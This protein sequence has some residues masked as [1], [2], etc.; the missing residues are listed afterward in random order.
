MIQFKDI[1]KTFESKTGIVHAVKEVNL[2]V[3]AGEIFGVIGYSGAGKSTLV[4]LINLLERPTSGSVYINGEDITLFSP[5]ALRERRKKIGMIFQQFNL[6]SARTVFENIALPLKRQGLSNDEIRTRVIELLELVGILDKS[7]AYPSQL[8]GGQKQRVAIA[9]ALAN[10]P[11]ILLCD[12]AT[13]ALDPQTTKTILKLL[14]DLN[15]KLN[16][17]IVVIT[18]EMEVVKEICDRVAVMQD[19]F[20]VEL[21]TVQQIFSNPQENITKEF[22]STTSNLSKLDDLLE[23]NSDI[24]HLEPHQKLLRIDFIGE[25]TSEA[26]ISQISKQYDTEA[27]IIFANVEVIKE[28]I[29]G[30]MVIRLSG[31]SSNQDAAIV[32]L[33]EIGI[34]V[35]VIKHGPVVS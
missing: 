15:K 5:K 6:L 13:S 7:K 16:I 12:E 17:T 19:G 1:S 29:L 24:I 28:E 34:K 27:S 22:I 32:H 35:E 31:Q 23:S 10:D 26:I 25:S 2:S 30:S 3:N 20:V 11:D 18:H 8:S 21:N 14:K 9:R 4:R 33:K